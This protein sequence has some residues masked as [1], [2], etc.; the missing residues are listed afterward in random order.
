MNSKVTISNESDV[1]KRSLHEVI[2]EIKTVYLDDNR[3]WIIGFSGGKDSTCMVQLVWTALSQLP[4]D[5]LQKK[6]YVI[7]SNTLVEAPQIAERIIGNLDKMEKYA[8]KI[9]LPLE[10]NLLRPLIQDTFWVRILGLGYPAPTNWFRWCTDM[11]KISNADRFIQETVS[12]HGE[13]IVLLGMRKN[14]SKI[15]NQVMELYKIENSLLSRHSKYAQ[16]YV[17]TPIED[18]SAE[19]VWN[20]LLENENPW[21]EVNRDLLTMY[22]D[23]NASECPLVIDTSS[24]SCG[25]GRFGCWTCTVVDNQSYFS[26]LIA[27]DKKNEWMEVLA[28]LREELKTTQ[29]EF[30]Y[31]C[32]KCKNEFAYDK[33]KRHYACTCDFIFKTLEVAE[34]DEN[35]DKIHNWNEFRERK[36]RDGV[37]TLKMGSSFAMVTAKAEGYTPGPYRMEF[38]KEYLEKLLK[39][40]LKV[41]KMKQDPDM[42]LIL[43]DE[44]HEIQK[45]WRMEQGDWKNSAYEIYNRIT[46]KNLQSKKN[47]MGHFEQTEQE[48]LEKICLDHN[49]PFRLVSNLLSLELKS[50]GANR[51]SRIHNK[52]KSELS[53]EWRDIENDEEFGKILEELKSKKMQK[54]KLGRMLEST[55][56]SDLNEK[57]MVR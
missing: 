34:K 56:E 40:Q 32:K 18:F 16:T 29:P 9:N 33:E 20:Y 57:N 1:K 17:Y 4:P 37:V 12:K 51:H 41:Q 22:Q 45:I 35:V 2:E 19:D 36:R 14:E 26:N 13:A 31:F 11:L 28:E 46:K 8:K 54:D 39:G 50:Q 25:G 5:K 23:A 21:G 38:R 53:K 44:I 47:E 43:E 3:P 30:R 52:I 48:I 24:A 27:S 42:E 10:T 7:S 15:R 49:V 6:I 55:S